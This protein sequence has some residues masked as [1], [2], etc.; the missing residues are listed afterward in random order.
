MEMI[1]NGTAVPAARE[2]ADVVGVPLDDENDQINNQVDNKN[3]KGKL[4]SST[5]SKKK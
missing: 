3:S 2:I 4:D 5:K 1:K